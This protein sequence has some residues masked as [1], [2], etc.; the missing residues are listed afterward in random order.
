MSV[1]V[2][3][4]LGALRRCPS[5]IVTTTRNIKISSSRF[6]ISKSNAE[7]QIK[8]SP[9][10]W[11][12]LGISAVLGAGLLGYMYYLR[13]KKD[14]ALARE[15]RRHLG[16]AAIGGTFEL[17]N[18]EGKLVKSQDFLG[19]WALIYFGFTHCPDI[20]PDEI[21]KMVGVVN[22]LEKDHNFKIHP[23]FISVD[24]S[25]D[26][27]SVVG[28]Y[29]KE[30]SEKIIGLTGNEEQVKNACKA[31]RVYF[32]S[33]PKDNDNDYIVDHT[34]IMYLVD[35]DGL[36]VDYYGQTQTVEQMVSS[37]ILN[38]IKLEKIKSG[39]WLPSLPFS[40]K[41]TALA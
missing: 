11:K 25:R 28:K 14:I 1:L 29:C 17:V 5:P 9:V 33:G 7:K 19:S 21:E 26:T 18:S 13:E 37:I 23:I 8:P 40:D 6:E 32:S 4:S 2:F 41:S 12:S 31:Y 35:P 15:R 20:C 27:P 34:I 16:K 36:F 22:A 3:R 10:S 39:S 38:K 30:F 24:P